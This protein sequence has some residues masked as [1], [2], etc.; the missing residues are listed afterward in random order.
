MQ[1]PYDERRP[2]DDVEAANVPSREPGASER[3]PESWPAWREK[4][5]HRHGGR[6]EAA[7]RRSL[8]E[9]DE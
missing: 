9:L 5:G 7:P 8:Y 4:T 2:P 3:Q 6:T 1:I